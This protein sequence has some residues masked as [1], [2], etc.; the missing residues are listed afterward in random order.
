MSPDFVLSYSYN[1]SFLSIVAVPPIGAQH[2]KTW[3]AHGEQSSWLDT[4]LLFRIIQARVLLYHYGDLRDDT[5]DTLGERLLNQLRN[6]RRNEVCY[7][8]R[9]LRE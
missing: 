9:F 8:V 5:V 6:E 4:E 7:P 1:N 2:R 3:T